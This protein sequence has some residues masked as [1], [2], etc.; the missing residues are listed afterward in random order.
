ML[1]VPLNICLEQQQETWFNSPRRGH[2]AWG[3]GTFCLNSVYS[4]K[5]TTGR[6][7]EYFCPEI[8]PMLTKITLLS[9]QMSHEMQCQKLIWKSEYIVWK[10]ACLFRM[11]SPWMAQ[12]PK[13]MCKR[14]QGCHRDRVARKGWMHHHWKGH[15]LLQTCALT[16]CSCYLMSGSEVDSAK[17]HLAELVSWPSEGS[18]L[19]IP[20]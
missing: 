8:L 7:G 15:I 14:P 3:A 16:D 10:S 12:I 19:I 4:I 13:R 5:C 2:L 1:S 9:Q 6:S 11:K 18:S 20:S 17:C